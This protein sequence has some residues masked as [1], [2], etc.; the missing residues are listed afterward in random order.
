MKTTK[1][2]LTGWYESELNESE[3][4]LRGWLKQSE[5]TQEEHEEMQ[6]IDNKI[7]FELGY[8]HA[9]KS[10]MVELSKIKNEDN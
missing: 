6:E 2:K 5:Y 7:Q 3:E 8:I 1:E 4:Y 9:M 10:L